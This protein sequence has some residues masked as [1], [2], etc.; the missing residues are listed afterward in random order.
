MYQFKFALAF[1]LMWVCLPTIFAVHQPITTS[2]SSSVTCTPP[3]I[4]VKELGTGTVN[5]EV[6]SGSGTIQYYFV[7]KENALSSTTRTTGN[8]PLVVS[9]L[10]AGTYIFYFRSVCNG[11]QS[12]WFRTE[13][14]ILG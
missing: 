7:R 8:G 9:G 2:I 1:G 14:L 4:A 6:L 5:F 12:E 11:E 3:S 10:P 13:D